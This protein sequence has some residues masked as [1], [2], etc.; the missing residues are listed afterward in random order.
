MKRQRFERD[1]RLSFWK[2]F[3]YE[4]S[5]VFVIIIANCLGVLLVYNKVKDND[6]NYISLVVVLYQ[7]AASAISS[8][9]VYIIRARIYSRNLQNICRAAQRVAA[10]DY[11]VRLEVYKDKIFKTEIDILKED[12]NTMVE[13]LTSIDRLRDDFVADVSHEI[14]T[15]LS[16]IQGYAE[17]INTPGIS[18]TKKHEYIGLL[19][20]AINNLTGL[21][22]N[23]LKLNKIENQGIVQKEKYSL[24]EQL[25]TCVLSFMD[26]IEE[27]NISLDIALDEVNVKSDKA[28]LEIVWNNLL[29]NAVKFTDNGGKIAVRLKKEGKDVTVEVADTG[30]GMTPEGCKRAFEKFY[31]CDSSH[32]QSGNGLGLALVRQVLNKLNGDISLHSKPGSGSVF[33]VRL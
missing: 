31:Q 25:R 19:T 15:P 32:S 28:L 20:E 2:S 27:K 4:F 1:D 26:K 10:G 23:V 16:I 14:K 8:I 3:L 9:L 24:D 21:V 13:E 5:I 6:I 11:G 22:S 17:L 33:T 30:C 12:F 18:E 7:F 29:S